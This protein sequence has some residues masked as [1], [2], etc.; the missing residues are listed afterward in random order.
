MQEGEKQK[1][2][3]SCGFARFQWLRFGAMMAQN[4]FLYGSKIH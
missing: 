3:C 4:L 1:S 2:E